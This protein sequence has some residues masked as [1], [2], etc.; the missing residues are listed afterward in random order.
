MD[1]L[2]AYLLDQLG[3]ND[4]VKLAFEFGELEKLLSSL[5]MEDVPEGELSF[6]DLTKLRI[7]LENI[8]SGISDRSD[9]IIVWLNDF[10]ASDTRELAG[11]GFSVVR[12]A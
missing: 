6:S 10:V 5:G 3:C 11:L 12:V 7:R 9:N 8:V 2:Y 4:E 1:N